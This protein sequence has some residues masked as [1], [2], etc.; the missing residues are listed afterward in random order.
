MPRCGGV[1]AGWPV[2][3]VGPQDDS[4]YFRRVNAHT[5]SVSI[6]RVRGRAVCIDN[7][8]PTTCETF[9]VETTDDDRASSLLGVLAPS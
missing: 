2:V 4:V 9:A 6:L 1:V 8:P 5:S 3:V 7:A